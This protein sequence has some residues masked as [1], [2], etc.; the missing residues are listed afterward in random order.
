MCLAI[1][2]QIIELDGDEALVDFKGNRMKVAV[3]LVP[4]ASEQDWVLVHAGFAITLIDEEEARITWSYLD[5]IS[6]LKR[7][8]GT[9]AAEDSDA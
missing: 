9:E 3:M 4:E 1:P 8:E 6:E 7:R 5:E 2:G